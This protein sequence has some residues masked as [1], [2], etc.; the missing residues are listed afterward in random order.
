[1][2]KIPLTLNKKDPEDRSRLQSERELAREQ[3]QPVAGWCGVGF[4]VIS[5]VFGPA[6]IFTPLGLLFSI[7]ALF[8]GQAGWGFVGLLLGVIGIFASL[9][10]WILIGA[11]AAYAIFDWNSILSPVYDMMRDG[12][13][14]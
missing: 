12:M 9:V 10:T 13:D 11:G 4:G 6:I 7:I 5:I 2:N 8:R 1:M 14:I 3:Q